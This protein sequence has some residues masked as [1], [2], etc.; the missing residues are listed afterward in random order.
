MDVLKSKLNVL[1]DKW[2]TEIE[3]SP[4]G[5]TVIDIS[6]VFEELFCRNIVHISFGEDVSEEM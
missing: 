1:I 3:A 4:E 5:K 2:N 6:T